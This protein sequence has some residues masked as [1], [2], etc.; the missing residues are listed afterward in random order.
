MIKNLKGNLRNT[1]NLWISRK[2]AKAITTR[3]NLKN[4]VALPSSMTSVDY[5]H[6]RKSNCFDIKVDVTRKLVQT[7]IYQINLTKL[8]HDASALGF[9][10]ILLQNEAG[11]EFSP[12][13][14]YPQ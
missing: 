3:H 10:C 2:K 13:Q 9:G 8:H 7:R 4:T 6:C 12:R 11:N 5:R 14:R 1:Q